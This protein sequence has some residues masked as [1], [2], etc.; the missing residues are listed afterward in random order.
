MIIEE[1]IS[2]NY[3]SISIGNEHIDQLIREI[4]D[5][6]RAINIIWV[7]TKDYTEL[8]QQII[9]LPYLLVFK[10]LR[11]NNDQWIAL[12]ATLT[13]SLSHHISSGEVT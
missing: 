7:R 5:S 12:F 6:T 9:Q 1:G 13:E 4:F 2:V 3:S 8:A 10:Y 11:L